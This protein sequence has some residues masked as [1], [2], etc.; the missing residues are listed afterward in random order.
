MK[1]EISEKGKIT[2]LAG[3]WDTGDT[4]RTDSRD[5]KNAGSQDSREISGWADREIGRR[6]AW[7]D[8]EIG[9]RRIFSET[10]LAFLKELSG[11]ILADSR[12]AAWPET[13]AFAFWCRE[14][15]LAAWKK[16]IPEYGR[17]KGRGLAFHVTP[18]NIPLLFA[19]SL[20]YGLLSGCGNVVRISPKLI[21]EFPVI[22][23]FCDVLENVWQQ[24]KYR[25]IY[26][27]NLV[28][29]YDHDEELNRYFSEKCAARIVWGGDKTV[30]AFRQIPVCPGCIQLEFPDRYSAAL[31]EE[32]W[33]AERS[34][35]EIRELAQRFYN[36]TY[37]ADQNACSGPKLIFWVKDSGK[38]L[39]GNTGKTEK[40]KVGTQIEEVESVRE[41][42]WAAVRETCENYPLD[43]M[44][45]SEKYAQLCRSLLDFDEI[46]QVHREDNFLYRVELKKCSRPLEEYQGKFGLF[47]ECEL[48]RAEDILPHLSRKIQ[49]IVY[50]GTDAEAVRTMILDNPVCGCDRVVSPGEALNLQAAWDGID[51]VRA[52][53]RVIG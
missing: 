48:D 2:V 36:D 28:I 43:A 8:Q 30:L 15:R 7:A 17:R 19:Y 3:G 53:S 34:Q 22:R 46:K 39:S 5:G 23:L 4:G 14:R 50:A 32:G 21:D 6:A 37:Q 10:V 18:S 52:L 38:N 45:A 12:T 13:A 24:E 9:G 26:R 49:T 31:F 47:Y 25:E 16:E 27:E 44:R 29:T 33:F 42:W 20:V 51:V 40:N 11:K 35:E 41:R 1:A